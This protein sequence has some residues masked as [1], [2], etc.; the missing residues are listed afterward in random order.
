MDYQQQI[1]VTMNFTKATLAAGTTTTLSTTGTTTFAISGKFYTK[2]A[3]T[4][5]ATPT[6]DYATGN[7]FIP[8][9][10]PLSSPNL[11]GVPNSAPGYGCVY[12]VGFDKSGAIK[13]VQG[14]IAALDVNGNFVTSPN[15]GA[16][17]EAPGTTWPPEYNNFCPIGYII[18]QLGSTAVATWTFGTNNLS[19]VTGVT[20]TFVD[21]ATLPGRPQV[22]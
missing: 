19:G 14:Q 6:K 13:V 18:V 21:V 8:I 12:V 22:S 7:A 17:G 4:N 15:F 11:A 9:P 16:V 1:P 10:I 3:I 5:G 2:T 20:Y